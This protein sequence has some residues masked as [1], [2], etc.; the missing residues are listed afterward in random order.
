MANKASVKDQQ[1]QVQENIHFQIKNMCKIMDEILRVDNKNIPDPPG[2]IPC[3]QNGP[4]RR[5]SGLSFAIGK[6][7][8][9]ANEPGEWLYCIYNALNFP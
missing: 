2:S 8:P 4:R 1:K 3:S 5:R 9:S 6:G 7:T